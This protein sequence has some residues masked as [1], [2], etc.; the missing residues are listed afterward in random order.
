MRTSPVLDKNGAKRAES[1][2]ITP[3]GMIKTPL[4]PSRDLTSSLSSGVTFSSGIPLPV[5]PAVDVAE[6][7]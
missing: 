1:G 6:W 5:M 4:K 3:P 2:E 7:E